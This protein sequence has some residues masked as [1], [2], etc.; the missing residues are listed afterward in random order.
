[1]IGRSVMAA[2]ASCAL[3]GTAAA[4][5]PRCWAPDE[6]GAARISELNIMLM[7]VHLRC[8][9]KGIDIS[10]SYDRFLTAN[11][12]AI[13]TAATGLKAHFGVT[14]GDRKQN[15]Y[16]SYMIGLANFYGAGKTDEQICRQFEVVATHL[17]N[18]GADGDLLA[19][20]AMQLVRDPR[21]DG[22][23]C[24]ARAR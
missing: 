7:D 22:P 11:R 12:K 2:L 8:R 23:R 9:S 19:T 24:P 1:M 3:A 16:D 6:I 4:Q 15:A 10:V 21:I 20:V 14:P 18:A 5:T 17:G 13:E